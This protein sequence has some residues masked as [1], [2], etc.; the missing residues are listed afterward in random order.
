MNILFVNNIFPL[1]ANA[2]SGASVR[3]MRLIKALLK[4]G[5]VDVISFVDGSP[6]I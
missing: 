3:S 5:H 4:L 1:F 6:C 2:N